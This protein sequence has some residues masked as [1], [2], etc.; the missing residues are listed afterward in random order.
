MKTKIEQKHIAFIESNTTGTGQLFIE[1]ARDKG[2]NP[3]FITANPNKYSYLSKILIQPVILDTKD[4]DVLLAF[5]QTIPNLKGVF[6]SSEYYIES[7]YSLAKS[8][9]LPANSPEV[10]RACRNKDMLADILSRN[11]IN[12]PRT[13]FVESAEA[14]IKAL[15]NSKINFPL[16]VK[17]SKGTGSIGVRLCYN[18]D[19]VLEYV[20]SQFTKTF[21]NTGQ[22]FGKILIQEYIDGDEYSVETVGTNHEIKIIGITKKYLSA[23][24]YFVET[25][26]DFPASLDTGLQQKIH[27]II[28][29]SFKALQLMFGPAHTEV[30]IK[31]GI[32]YIIEINPR[33]AGGMIPKIVKTATGIDLIDATIDLVTGNTPRLVNKFDQYSAI[34]F[35]IPKSGG[36]LKSVNFNY[37][38]AN[39]L[40]EFRVNKKQDDELLLQGDYRDRI[41]HFVVKQHSS[42]A[43]QQLADELLA[44]ASIEVEPN[45]QNSVNNMN[46]TGR[47]KSSLR[48]EA[49]KLIYKKNLPNKKLQE[50]KL[51]AKIDEAH[52][53]MLHET[54]LINKVHAV[55]LLKEIDNL[56]TTKFISV[57]H[58]PSPRGIYLSYENHFIQTL[59]ADIG[60]MS[61]IGRSRNDINATMFKL[62]LKDDFYQLYHNL[63]HLRSILASQAKINLNTPLPIYSQY[64]T[65][66]PGTLA[67]YYLGLE[68]ALARDQQALKA[69][70]S[71]I[72]CCP[73]GAGAGGGTTLPISQAITAKLL[74]FSSYNT[75]SLDAVASR[76]A[77]ARVL[78]ALG[79]CA[80]TLSRFTEDLQL[81]STNEFKFVDFP[82]DLVGGS[83]MMPQKK[84][85]YL[86]EKI[87][88]ELASLLG[89][90]VTALHTMFKVPFG[91][92][93]EVST[94]A[95]KLLDNA[96]NSFNTAVSLLVIIV[97]AIIINEENIKANQLNNLTGA[98]YLTDVLLQ[99]NEYSFREA[100]HLI[101]KKIRHAI[102]H[103]LNPF[104]ELLTISEHIKPDDLD[105]LTIALKMEYG[106]GAGIKVVTS[107]Y[108]DAVKRLTTDGD[109]LNELQLATETA[110]K[111]HEKTVNL[112]LQ[113]AQR[114]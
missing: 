43:C 36:H 75:N 41:G 2:F 113:T 34:R 80:M 64:Q 77:G 17:P 16:I 13:L 12:C 109:W 22:D 19:E 112:M 63:W 10:I 89:Y 73:L 32:P 35:F 114:L 62:K 84:N 106:G 48:P 1:T 11:H 90:Y 68:N 100:H 29:A 49:Q 83:S 65:A 38:V 98:T 5:L 71:D 61:H 81:W 9:G 14:L 94:E 4:N 20:R 46:D 33:L 23:P 69:I 87:K 107:Q 24:P 53:I 56:K 7:A 102:D 28:H 39:N 79:I 108:F 59:G 72:N 44:S 37:R 86:L 55:S 60:G 27:E 70:Y 6:S 31:E 45:T 85:P 52:I 111:I 88:G 8:L 30:R 40:V 101:G 18:K 15:D 58:Q 91:N 92:S 54:K 42:A 82:D 57:I 50:L 51:L 76:D 99:N 104:S 26:H 74:G 103:S 95:I 67:H 105:P 25:G 21:N 110:N 47:L 96:F 93:V 97:Q 3:V 78:A 66:L